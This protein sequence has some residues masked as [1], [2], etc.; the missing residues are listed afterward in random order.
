MT[1]VYDDVFYFFR[2]FKICLPPTHFGI[3]KVSADFPKFLEICETPEHWS[4][5]NRVQP[6]RIISTWRSVNDSS[7]T[8]T[9]LVQERRN[10]SK[11]TF[12]FLEKAWTSFWFDS[13]RW[14]ETKINCSISCDL[15]GRITSS[16]RKITKEFSTVTCLQ[17][18]R[19]KWRSYS[20]LWSKKTL[21][22]IG[23]WYMPCSQNIPL[24]MSISTDL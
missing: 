8:K 15:W 5:D 2:Y 11:N 22:R 20:L 17:L 7:T 24:C 12:K 14:F 9:S 16:T 1:S 18:W 23:I 13:Q 6:C 21:T 10:A 3:F 4:E 19:E